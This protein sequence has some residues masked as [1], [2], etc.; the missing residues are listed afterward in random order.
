MKNAGSNRRLIYAI[1]IVVGIAYALVVT[2][3]YV[4]SWRILIP[5][6]TS[7]I[8]DLAF[9]GFWLGIELWP[10]TIVVT[11]LRLSALRSILVITGYLVLLSIAMLAF[12]GWNMGEAIGLFINFG[13]NLGLQLP[14]AL[15]T[16]FAVKMI[17]RGAETS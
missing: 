11:A 3:W 12:S 16:W 2:D 17:A 13:P 7:T 9:R 6:M 4:S 8:G 15:L 14:V 5:L 10:I 1:L